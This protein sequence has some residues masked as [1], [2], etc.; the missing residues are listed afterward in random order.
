MAIIAGELLSTARW[1][2]A[3]I[4]AFVVFSGTTSRGQTLS[5]GWQRLLGTA[6]GVPAGVLIAT[7]VGGN[8]ILSVIL[9]FVC[10]FFAFYLVQIA[11]SLMIFWITTMLALLYGL[12]GQ[13][14]IGLLL[15][16]IGE[17]AIGAA[18]GV[19]VALLVLPTSTRASIRDAVRDFLTALDELIDVAAH[20]PAGDPAADPT[21]RAR[22]LDQRLQELRKVAE[23]MTRG[24]AGIRDRG[25]AHHAMRVLTTCDHYA[26]AFARTG[27]QTVR[28]DPALRADM[29]S[30]ADLIR[31]NIAALIDLLDHRQATVRL[32][33]EVL[34]TVELRVAQHDPPGSGA[35][36][37]ADRARL[38]AAVRSLRHID[39]AIRRLAQDLGASEMA[40]TDAD[41]HPLASTA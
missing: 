21:E 41:Q 9:I 24:I 33:T 22:R 3:V 23:P 30:A 12:L 18:I 40:A 37:S 17:T 7:G 31:Q 20:S 34:D 16:R 32:A 8:A 14:S 5:K 15:L 38:L 35:G 27:C 6:V 19:L 26:R 39:Q 13:F 36:A 4:A 25:S 2:W 1:Y 29:D 28:A 10:M 11:Y